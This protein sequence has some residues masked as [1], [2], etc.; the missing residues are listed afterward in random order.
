[1]NEKSETPSPVRSPE[2]LAGFVATQK[3]YPSGLKYLEVTHGKT[4]I[5]SC[6]IQPSG[7][8][9]VM[10]KRKP[11]ATVRA[12]VLQMLGD[13]LNTCRKEELKWRKKLS[14]FKNTYPP[15]DKAHL[16]GQ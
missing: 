8:F 14:H 15:N 12:A 13:H 7:G 11:V 10:G 6:C 2:W 5:G 3:Q 9:I 4:R 16:P 1:M